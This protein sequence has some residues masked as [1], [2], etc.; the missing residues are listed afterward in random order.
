MLTPLTLNVYTFISKLYALTEVASSVKQ[1]LIMPG[2]A[3]LL[4]ETLFNNDKTKIN[5]KLRYV[6]SQTYLQLFMHLPTQ[7]SRQVH[8]AV[9]KNQKQAWVR[10]LENRRAIDVTYFL[11]TLTMLTPFALKTYT[12][13]GNIY[14]FSQK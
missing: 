2:S 6:K 3:I 11:S 13:I 5:I 10:M 8:T 14:I 9:V 4:E 12:F 7:P 1:Y